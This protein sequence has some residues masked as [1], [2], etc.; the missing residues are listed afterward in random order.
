MNINFQR[1]TS[2]SDIL[3]RNECFN[4]VYGGTLIAKVP[5]SWKKSF[6]MDVVIPNKRRNCGDCT[7]NNFCDNC[8][9]L[10]NQKKEFS[11]DPHD[12]KRQAPNEFGQMFLKYK[13]T[14]MWYYINQSF[15]IE[16]YLQREKKYTISVGW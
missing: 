1:F 16:I 11:A 4:M 6:S 10:V 15:N 13:T 3:H 5:S 9:K 8:D 12:L 2:V 7:I 14:W